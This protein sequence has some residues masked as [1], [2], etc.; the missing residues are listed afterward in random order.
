MTT[1]NYELR[2]LHEWLHK[3][4]NYANYTN[5]WIDRTSN[6][7]STSFTRKIFLLKKNI[8]YILVNMKIPKL[9]KYPDLQIYT[10][11]TYFLIS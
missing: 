2:E 5:G 7:L 3:T 8:I 6:W 10:Y 4:T 9:V 11:K 1:Q